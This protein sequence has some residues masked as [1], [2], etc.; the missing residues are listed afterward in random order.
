MHTNELWKHSLTCG[1]LAW[2]G[3][4]LCGLSS[5]VCAQPPLSSPEVKPQVPV[6]SLVPPL[7]RVK[8]TIAKAPDSMDGKVN[9]LNA[10][11]FSV[12]EAIK[13]ANPGALTVKNAMAL[14]AAIIEDDQID[15][16]E[17][18]LL[19]EITQSQFR[20][21]TIT[22]AGVAEKP[23]TLRTYPCSGYAKTV[24]RE[25]LDPQ[26]N[27]EESWAAGMAG[28][29]D[30]I[31]DSKK[32]QTNE[33]RVAAYLEARV[34]DAWEASNQGNG[35]KPLRDLLARRYGFSKAPDFPA[36]LTGIARKLMIDA[37]RAVDTKAGDQIPDFI[38]TWW[39]PGVHP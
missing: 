39:Q 14:R 5:M 20:S 25:T 34:A 7:P 23:P 32:N 2:S 1:I 36:D 35:Y 33:Q 17:A 30:M 4:V 6:G 12:F 11:V 18:D 26:L 31:L 22:K 38:Y 28:W 29:R 8:G 19:S 21:V 10:E 15:A 27:L 3:A 24:L 37:C 16:M 9:G 13:R